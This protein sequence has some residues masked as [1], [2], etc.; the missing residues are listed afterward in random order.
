MVRRVFERATSRT[1][2][3]AFALGLWLGFLGAVRVVEECLAAESPRE[4]M[5]ACPAWMRTKVRAATRSP[6][7]LR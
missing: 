6:G 5:L 1:A 2:I 4:V 7:S 3:V